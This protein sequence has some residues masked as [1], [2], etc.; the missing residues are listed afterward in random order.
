MS[1]P[2]RACHESADVVHLQSE[3]VSDSVRKEHA[4]DPR[5]DR[6]LGT[7]GRYVSFAKQL[8]SQLVRAQVDVAPVHARRAGRRTKSCC[9]LVHALDEGREIAT[10]KRVSARDIAGVAAKLRARIDQE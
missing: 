2:F 9:I 8:P 1:P 5:G 3:Q 6:L 7:A 10:A 4:R